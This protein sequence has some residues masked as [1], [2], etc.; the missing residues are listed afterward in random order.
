VDCDRF[1]SKGRA[2]YPDGGPIT[3]LH[4]SNFR[5]VKRVFDIVRAFERIRRSIDAKLVMIGD[6]PQRGDAAELAAELNISTHVEFPG[7]QVDI[8]QAYRDA[9]LFLLLSDYESFGLSALEAMACGTPVVATRAGGLVEVVDDGVAGRLCPVGDVDAVAEAAL[10]IV[11]DRESW[12]SHSEASKRHA[13]AN[14][15]KELIVPMYE[16]FYERV[17]AGESDAATKR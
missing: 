2:G 14:F 1:T 4:A 3:I 13:R 17:L 9:H 6:G 11:G 12:V 16:Q 8:E 5:P 15:C 10:A 7:K